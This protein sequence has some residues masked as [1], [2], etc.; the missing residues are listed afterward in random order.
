MMAAHEALHTLAMTRPRPSEL[1]TLTNRR[2]YS[3]GKRSFVALGYF[4]AGADG[5]CLRYLVAGQP[6]PLLRRK[7]GRVSELPLPEHRIPVGAL[8]EGEY[9]DLEIDLEPGDLVLGYS[10]G[11]TEACSP[12]GELFGDL[13][14][15]RIVADAGTPGRP[16]DPDHL[17]EDVLAAVS[18][19]SGGG[20]QS[21]DLTLVAV[22]R[23]LEAGG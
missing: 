22:G 10:D 20:M 19:W 4:S 14:L 15:Q 17:V 8:H 12:D 23:T 6:A 1:F 18:E 5:R 21:D 11:V 7:D 9:R 3:I 13:R 2:L 16:L